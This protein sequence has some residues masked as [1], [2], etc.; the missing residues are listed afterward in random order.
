MLKNNSSK[1]VDDL[2]PVLSTYGYPVISPNLERLKKVS[3][4]FRN[5]YVSIAVCA[6]SRTA[7]LTGLRP[8]TTQVWTIGPYFRNT[9]R[10]Q[11]HKVTTLPQMFKQAG[12]NVTGAGECASMFRLVDVIYMCREDLPSRHS[13]RWFEYERGRWRHVSWAGLESELHLDE[14]QC[15]RFGQL[16]RAILL[17]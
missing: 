11:G 3:T 13:F 1:V 6:P 14:V 12:Y 2:A 15:H 8:D 16:D 17:L 4:Q 5:A 10:G 7:F 9:S